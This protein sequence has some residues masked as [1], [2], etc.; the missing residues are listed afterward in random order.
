[1]KTM[2]FAIGAAMSL[3]AFG[4]AYAGEGEGVGPNS[5]FTQ[6]AGVVAE[7]ATPSPRAVVMARTGASPQYFFARSHRGTWLF[8]ADEVGGGN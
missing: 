7:A 4:V 1:M 2:L 8:P 6:V 5:Q 3:S